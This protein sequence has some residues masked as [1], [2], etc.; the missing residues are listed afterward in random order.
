[1][2]LAVVSYSFAIVNQCCRSWSSVSCGESARGDSSYKIQSATVSVRGD[3]SCST[4]FGRL[5]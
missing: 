1:M 5:Q 4:E 2:S 3:P